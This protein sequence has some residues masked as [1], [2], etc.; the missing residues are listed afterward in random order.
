MV[1][2]GS[3]WSFGAPARNDFSSL[4]VPTTTIRPSGTF[5]SSRSYRSF[6]STSRRSSSGVAHE[7]TVGT[8]PSGTP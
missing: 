6:S 7:E 5:S 8:S 2:T 1:S 4:R 3:P